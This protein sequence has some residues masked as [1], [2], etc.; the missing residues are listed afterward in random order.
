LQVGE[1]KKTPASKSELYILSHSLT[2]QDLSH[3]NF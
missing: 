3:L 2:E 1:L